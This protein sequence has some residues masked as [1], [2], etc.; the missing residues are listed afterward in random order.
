MSKVA[1]RNWKPSERSAEERNML[2]IVYIVSPKLKCQKL[3]RVTVCLMELRVMSSIQSFWPKSNMK[4]TH[5]HV[6]TNVSSNDQNSEFNVKA[7]TIKFKQTFYNKLS[8]AKSWERVGL[9]RDSC[10]FTKQCARKK[11]KLSDAMKIKT[12]KIY[13]NHLNLR[14]S[15]QLKFTTIN[16]I[17]PQRFWISYTKSHVKNTN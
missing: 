11:Q 5:L 13:N 9:N 14:R 17:L 10:T 2:S 8:N 1:R 12:I 4:T 7:F 15:K 16:W 3:W 6:A